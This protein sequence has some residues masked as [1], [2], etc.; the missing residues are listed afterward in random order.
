MARMLEIRNTLMAFMFF[1]A[2]TANLFAQTSTGEHVMN[3]RQKQLVDQG[4][5]RLKE[6]I[7]G[8][9]WGSVVWDEAS[10]PWLFAHY[11]NDEELAR[12]AD[13]HDNANVRA[14]AVWCYME[15]APHKSKELFFRHV[16][17]SGEVKNEGGCIPHNCSM[18]DFLIRKAGDLD[19]LSKDEYV[20]LDSLL[21]HS[22]SAYNVSRRNEIIKSLELT[23][24]NKGLVRRY[25]MNPYDFVSLN[26]LAE[27]HELCDTVLI[28]NALY[29]AFKPNNFIKRRNYSHT[30]KPII[31]H[32]VYLVAN[33]RHPSFKRHLLALRDTLVAANGYVPETMFRCAFF[34]E[35]DWTKEFVDG[36]LA[37]A[38]SR[39]DNEVTQQFSHGKHVGKTALELKKALKNRGDYYYSENGNII[40]Y[41]CRHIAS[42][43]DVFDLSDSVEDLKD[44]L[45]TISEMYSK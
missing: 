14:V 7:S 27:I 26:Y 29:E 43:S 17:E 40:M 30:L 32:A 15:R 18:G 19:Y 39:P 25:A 36:S 35:A 41:G 31:G 20:L 33:W 34:Y 12:L 13:T 1:V 9:M 8:N 3:A 2:C 28:I 6:G 44:Y 24:A 22:A 21:L 11:L 10:A 23:A 45:E 38:A 5:E 4:I 42:F 16:V 37:L